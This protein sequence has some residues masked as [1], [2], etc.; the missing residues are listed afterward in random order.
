MDINYL[1][2]DELAAAVDL[3]LFRIFEQV[4]RHEKLKDDYLYLTIA[5]ECR[6]NEITVS[7]SITIGY[8]DKHKIKCGNLFEALDTIRERLET[9]KPCDPRTMTLALPAPKADTEYHDYEDVKD[10]Y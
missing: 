10:G 6:N 2:N 4:K 9:E 5:T 1:T 3:Y 8:D 7:H